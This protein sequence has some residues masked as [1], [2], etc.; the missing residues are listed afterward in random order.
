MLRSLRQSCDIWVKILI[1]HKFKFDHK[2]QRIFLR[3]IAKKRVISLRKQCLLWL[4]WWFGENCSFRQ[5]NDKTELFFISIE[6]CICTFVT[7][8]QTFPDHW[9]AFN[10]QWTYGKQRKPQNW[11]IPPS[12]WSFSAFCVCTAFFKYKHGIFLDV[13]SKKEC[14]LF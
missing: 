13:I 9:L 5:K 11:I 8:Q 12:E 2:V 3:A 1:I 6:I 4:Y 7:A 10:F 14:F